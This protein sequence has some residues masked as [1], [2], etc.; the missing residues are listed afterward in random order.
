MFVGV[1][2]SQG[3]LTPLN[4]HPVP[5]SQ[6]VGKARSKVKAARKV[7][8]LSSKVYSTMMQASFPTLLPFSCVGHVLGCL[9]ATRQQLAG[10][11]IKA[12][13]PVTKL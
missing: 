12:F 4:G 5:G 11:L 9:L 10:Y 2:G 3:Q 7:G 13:I 6:I 8:G 1:L